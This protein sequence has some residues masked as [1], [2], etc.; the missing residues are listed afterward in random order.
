[1]PVLSL[2]EDN[3]SRLGQPPGNEEKEQKL[4]E[5]MQTLSKLLE[6]VDALM[7]EDSTESRPST[8]QSRP[9]STAAT[10][11]HPERNALARP[12]TGRSDFSSCSR[13]ELC[14]L[15][16][17]AGLPTVQ[18]AGVQCHTAGIQRLRKITGARAAQS[19]IA[20]LLGG[21]ASSP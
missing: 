16:I 14:G 4:L 2:T 21:G 13:R 5:K 6:Q 17:N 3:L 12:L 7:Q 8:Q 20:D 10:S 9:P 19:S 15:P 18:Y 11:V 1:M